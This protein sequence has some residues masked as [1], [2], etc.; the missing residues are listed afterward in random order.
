M[1]TDARASAKEACLFCRA[2][3]RKTKLT[4]RLSAYGPLYR[5]CGFRTIG[6][7][8]FGRPKY[9]AI[10]PLRCNICRNTGR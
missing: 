5:S 3:R 9:L 2:R 4:E 6:R 7:L 1:L 10:L 8:H